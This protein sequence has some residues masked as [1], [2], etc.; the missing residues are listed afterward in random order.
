[1]R[2]AIG[3]VQVKVIRYS[4]NLV[5]DA[6]AVEYAETPHCN[7]TPPPGIKF[8]YITVAIQPH[9]LSLYHSLHTPRLHIPITCSYPLS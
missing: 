5:D 3:R 4:S 2:A 6:S 1:V 9:S 7:A 8:P